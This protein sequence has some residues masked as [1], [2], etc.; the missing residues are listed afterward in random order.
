VIQ[1]GGEIEVIHQ[2]EAFEKVGSIGAFLRY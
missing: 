2:N 1:T